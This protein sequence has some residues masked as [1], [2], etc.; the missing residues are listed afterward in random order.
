MNITF[1]DFYKNFKL[2]KNPI[3]S[4]SPYENTML[5]YGEKELDY[6]EDQDRNT[7]WSLL[8]DGKNLIIAPGLQFKNVIGYFIT[9]KKWCTKDKYVLN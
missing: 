1:N 3:E 7:I 8:D 6:L 2:K 9:E 4:I 5:D